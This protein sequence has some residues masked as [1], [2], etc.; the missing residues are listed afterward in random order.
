MP[1]APLLT[2]EVRPGEAIVRVLEQAGVDAVFGMVGGET[3]RIFDALYDR[4]SSVR[5]VAVREESL[6]GVMAEVYGRL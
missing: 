6:A 2:E 5:F 1:T 4:R 3:F